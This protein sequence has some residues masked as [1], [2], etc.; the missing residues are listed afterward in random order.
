MSRKS[1]FILTILLMVGIFLMLDAVVFMMV[2]AD[3]IGYIWLCILVGLEI[4]VVIVIPVV[5]FLAKTFL[6]PNIVLT[7]KLFVSPKSWAVK[8]VRYGEDGE[9]DRFVCDPHEMTIDQVSGEVNTTP[10]NA[11]IHETLIH[12]LIGV[13]WIG[14]PPYQVAGWKMRWSRAS[15]PGET[16][17]DESH[18]LFK[19]Q[20]VVHR[21][22]TVDHLTSNH[23]ITDYWPV[24]LADGS[25]VI[26]KAS[27][28]LKLRNARLAIL[29]QP[30]WYTLA[31]ASVDQELQ[32]FVLEYQADNNNWK[33][34]IEVTDEATGTKKKRKVL[35]LLAKT[36]KDAPIKTK[37]VDGVVVEDEDDESD[38]SPFIKSLRAKTG[39]RLSKFTF[40]SSDPQNE[41]LK[42]VND[43]VAINVQE[44]IVTISTA[45]AEAKATERRARAEKYR[46]QQIGLGN[47]AGIKNELDA[48]G[49]DL[50]SRRIHLNARVVKDVPA[51]VKVLTINYGG[52]ASAPNTIVDI[53]NVND[54]SPA[55]GAGSGDTGG[56]DDKSAP[57]VAPKTVPPTGT[58][59]NKTPGGRPKARP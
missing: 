21:Y 22:E 51:G 58:P 41:K 10:K 54:E 53:G 42:E 39:F 19:E 56:G 36:F 59:R 25:E 11:I 12:Q 29:E 47:K 17:S 30:D 23:S 4:V 45:E 26:I 32:K 31:Y 3:I 1:L 20:G 14:L 7:H 38:D 27:F 16:E 48:V 13:E 6:V 43:K 46:L 37:I 34:E 24:R 18:Q 52:N 5:L 33:N 49:S 57:P 9:F 50:I 44:N 55:G 28:K 35:D 40:T 2:L 15:K 8:V